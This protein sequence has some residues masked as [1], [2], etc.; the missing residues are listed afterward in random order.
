[1][2]TPGSDPSA[3]TL[4][5]DGALWFTEWDGNKIG[6]ITTAG[7]IIEFDLPTANAEPYGITVG[8]DGA[9]WF[10]EVQPNASQIG[11]ITTSGVVTEYPVPTPISGGARAWQQLWPPLDRERA[12]RR[13]VVH[14]L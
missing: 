12:R 9:L 8:P 7:T 13:S 5:P 4:G 1:V 3:I 10:V 11:H 2:P 14:Q 6:R